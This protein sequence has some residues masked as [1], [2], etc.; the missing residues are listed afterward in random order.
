MCVHIM[1]EIKEIND[2]ALIAEVLGAVVQE[3]NE[4]VWVVPFSEEIHKQMCEELF[5]RFIIADN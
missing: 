2:T 1:E 5:T 3:K 4:L